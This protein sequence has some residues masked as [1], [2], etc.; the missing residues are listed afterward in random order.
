MDTR[1]LTRWDLL[2]IVMLLIA[3]PAGIY[4]F[5]SGRYA[6]GQ[7]AVIAIVI[8]LAALIYSMR[9]REV[10]LVE[11]EPSAPARRPRTPRSEPARGP[12]GRIH[13]WLS[14]GMLSGFVAT[15]LMTSVLLVGYG[16]AA[17]VASASSTAGTLARWSEALIHNQVTATTQDNLALAI[18]LHFV[19][20][21]AWAIVYAGL[22]EP[23]LE[24]PGWQRGLTFA[25]VP[26]LFSLIVFLPITGGGF[27][28]L[29]V[30]AGPLPIIGN[31]IL[32]AFY[33]VA[34]GE[35]FISEGL[36]TEDGRVRDEAEPATLTRIQRR[37]AFAVVPG[38]LI[39]GLLGLLGSSV[40]APGVAPATVT[41]V[42]AIIGCVVGV[43]I[44][45][46]ASSAPA[47]PARG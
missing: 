5:A 45:S 13:D 19:A 36:L 14:S 22:V 21:L 38:L 34:L 40:V 43:V 24:G 35:V 6:N 4:H 42:G 32:H 15:A 12:D 31:F 33:G 29:D 3:A 25:V 47:P 7:M 16:I 20:G 11:A 26:W 1:G 18:A 2:F 23:R 46:Y 17:M 39:G 44:G 9:H 41:V 27:L 28:G 30:G 37:I 8:G 10:A